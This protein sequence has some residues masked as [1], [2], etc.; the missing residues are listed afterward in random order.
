MSRTKLNFRF[1]NPNS[2]EETAEYIAKLFIKVNQAK[3]E[4]LFQNALEAQDV[5]AESFDLK[6]QLTEHCQNAVTEIKDKCYC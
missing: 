1:H 5:Q 6:Q 4:R 3:V 2:A